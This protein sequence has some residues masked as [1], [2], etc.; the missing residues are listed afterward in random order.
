MK[1][2]SEASWVQGDSYEEKPDSA[3]DGHTVPAVLAHSSLE[4]VTISEILAM[5]QQLDARKLKKAKE[6][7]QIA[8]MD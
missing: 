3:Q 7:I 6:L 8:F 1:D 2:T 4:S 5:L